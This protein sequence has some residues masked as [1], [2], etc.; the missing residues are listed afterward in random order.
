MSKYSTLQCGKPQER[1]A[2]LL[3]WNKEK[4]GEEKREN[5][6]RKVMG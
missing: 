3:K 2:R 4:G 1:M 5:E 6:A